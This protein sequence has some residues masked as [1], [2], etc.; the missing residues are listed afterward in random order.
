MTSPTNGEILSA[1]FDWAAYGSQDSP[2]PEVAGLS[3][4]TRQVLWDGASELCQVIRDKV[5]GMS[6]KPD[7]ER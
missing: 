5:A 7:D 1:S 2:P 6:S 3:D 4:D